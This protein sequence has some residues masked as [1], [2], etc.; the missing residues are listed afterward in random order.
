[1][2]IIDGDVEREWV[3]GVLHMIKNRYAVIALLLFLLITSCGSAGSTEFDQT[4]TPSD[5]IAEALLPETDEDAE[6]LD[7]VLPDISGDK[8]TEAHIVSL[9]K[10]DDE[11]ETI[12]VQDDEENTEEDLTVTDIDKPLVALTFDDGPTTTTTVEIL[13]K[14]EEYGIVASFF[15]I[16]DMINEKSAEVMKRAFDMGCEIDNHSKTHSNM[17]KLSADVIAAE[18]EHTSAKIEEIV[19]VRPKFF[20]PPFIAV[21]NLLFDTVDLPFI[22]GVGGKDWDRNYDAKYRSDKIL[23]QVKDGVIILMHDYAGNKMTVE[24]LD[25]I[26]PA[27]LEQD[28]RFVTVSQMFELKSVTPE[29]HNR[30]LYT[31]VG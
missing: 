4:G 26:I 5:D 20:R 28:Y 23:E 27:L 14:L 24:A 25:T 3:I 8:D 10:R 2:D 6:I 9:E 12:T 15:V 31:E 13:D 19:G 21:N 29:I 17:G 22:C 7:T 1:M 11:D 16:G 18:I 30:K